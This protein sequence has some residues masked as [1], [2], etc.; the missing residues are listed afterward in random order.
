MYE[1][2]S[3]NP[4]HLWDE[5]GAAGAGAAGTVSTAAGG[6]ARAFIPPA[7]PPYTEEY[8]P[9]HLP[10][11]NGDY[12]YATGDNAY[13]QQGEGNYYH[14]DGPYASN[15]THYNGEYQDSSKTY[16]DYGYYNQP[17][18][19]GALGFAGAGTAF[20]SV[21]HDPM[22]QS[23]STDPHSVHGNPIQH[24]EGTDPHS[25]Y[26]KPDARE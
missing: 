12:Y 26:S 20:G 18:T 25:T 3:N 22:Q 6:S 11:T 5:S 23:E 15:N 2:K 14:A 8:A 24:S 1:Y 19:D 16:D 4:G 9:A 17:Y 13:L 10:T 7:N 21:N